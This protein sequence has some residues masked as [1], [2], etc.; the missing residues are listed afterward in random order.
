MADC[1]SRSVAGSRVRGSELAEFV[2]AE[3][4]AVTVGESAV[5]AAAHL[6]ADSG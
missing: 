1:A 4:I 2:M 6:A 3:A 5:P